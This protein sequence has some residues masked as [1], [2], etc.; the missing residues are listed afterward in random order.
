LTAPA[1]PALG[2]DVVTAAVADAE[3]EDPE[4]ELVFADELD[5]L[6]EVLELP[7]VVDEA[8]VVED[9]DVLVELAVDVV[10]P[11]ADAEEEDEDE[12]PSHVPTQVAPEMSKPGV[13]L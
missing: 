2:A 13:K 11:L 5:A 7:L 12:E 4:L 10:V 3:L 8:E 9:A 6:P 1:P